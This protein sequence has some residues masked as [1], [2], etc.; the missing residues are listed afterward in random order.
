MSKKY[1]KCSSKKSKNN[2]IGT[3]ILKLKVYSAIGLPSNS[4][5]YDIMIT[6]YHQ[7]Q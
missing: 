2:L 4:N 3:Y 7:I 5:H 1:K 6:G